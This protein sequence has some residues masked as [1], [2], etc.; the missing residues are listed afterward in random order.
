LVKQKA[1][2]ALVKQKAFV[3]LMNF[4]PAAI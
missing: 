2:V 1:A 4:N 3:T